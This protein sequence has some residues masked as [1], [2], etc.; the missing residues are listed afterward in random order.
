MWTLW[1][2]KC[3]R[4][5]AES[6]FR[7]YVDQTNS[8]LDSNRVNDTLST[9]QDSTQSPENN[10]LVINETVE[11]P[12][13]ETPTG[14]VA[15]QP[16]QVV[17]TQLR[18]S[19]VLRKI[20]IL[21]DMISTVQKEISKLTKEV[22]DLA[23]QHV[24]NQT[25]YRTVDETNTS[26]PSLTHSLDN[27]VSQHDGAQE[28]VP[29]SSDART[30]NMLD[31]NPPSPNS[32]LPDPQTRPYNEVLRTSTPRDSTNETPH[33]PRPAQGINPTSES[34]QRVTHNDKSEQILLIGDSL[35]SKVNPKGLAPNVIKNGVSGG[36]I[37]KISSQIKVYDIRKFS[38]V[39]IYVGGNDASSGTDVEYF[40]E[41][42]DQVIQHI[43]ESNNQCK[44]VLCTSCPPG[45]HM[46]IRSEQ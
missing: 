34:A 17:L 42:F 46:C 25:L 20:S 43:K 15:Q 45:S 16:E 26:S 19:L 31:S 12:E 11:E 6:I 2:D 22:N 44:I 14:S 37:D 33:R 13:A 41:K 5:L 18:D 30:P 10:G 39:I 24:A 40:E 9:S 27:E 1:K 36:N 32:Q 8:M 21:V 7:T 29:I 35:I 38:H 3:F 4:K 28:E 23:G